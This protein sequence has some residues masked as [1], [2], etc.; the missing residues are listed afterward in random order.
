[1]EQGFKLGDMLR[2]KALATIKIE[3]FDLKTDPC[4]PKPIMTEKMKLAPLIGIMFACF[5]SCI[6]D[7]YCARWRSMICNK[8]FPERATSRSRYLYKKILAGR[9]QRR[10]Q[11]RLIAI[12]EKFKADRLLEISIGGKLSQCWNGLMGRLGIQ[13]KKVVCHGCF[14]K[15]K[16]KSSIEKQYQDKG[17]DVTVRLCN[18][19]NKDV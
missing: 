11:L 5:I 2:N 10:F 17:E 3:A 13:E 4:L 6:L 7:A 18:D 9:G 12:R 8:F 1:M 15:T 19:C 14:L 16:K